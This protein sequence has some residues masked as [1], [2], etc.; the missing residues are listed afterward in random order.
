MIERLAQHIDS[1]SQVIEVETNDIKAELTDKLGICG[2]NYILR[3]EGELKKGE[4]Y[5][6]T[7]GNLFDKIPLILSSKP[8][9][10]I[11]VMRNSAD[12]WYMEHIAVYRINN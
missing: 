5:L 11:R 3:V 12:G 7:G 8:N 2:D 6:L 9:F 4:H 1:S 10:E